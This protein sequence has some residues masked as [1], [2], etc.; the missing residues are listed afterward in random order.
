MSVF[1]ATDPRNRKPTNAE[2]TGAIL[3]MAEAI[4]FFP[5]SELGQ[6]IVI[7]ALENFV[8]TVEQLEW[9]RDAAVCHMRRWSLPDLRGMFCTRWAPAD[10]R[11]ESCEIPGFTAADRDAALFRREAEETDRRIEGWKKEKQLAPPETWAPF[12]ALPAAKR[13]P[14]A[15]VRD[16]SEQNRTRVAPLAEVEREVLA[17]MR[18]ARSPEENERLARELEAEVRRRQA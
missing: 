7:Q 2:I 3:V 17:S 11:H 9:L 4:P 1:N 8:S 10:G 12:P 16:D 18:P 15:N 6:L 14:S 5:Q 13:I